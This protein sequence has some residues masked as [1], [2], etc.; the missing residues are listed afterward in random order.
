MVILK[1]QLPLKCDPRVILVFPLFLLPLPQSYQAE[2]PSA[3]RV[4]KPA[5]TYH[6]R[7]SGFA[8][9]AGQLEPLTMFTPT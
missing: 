9:L 1:M 5:G 8:R 7:R 3:A 6:P 2:L 4:G